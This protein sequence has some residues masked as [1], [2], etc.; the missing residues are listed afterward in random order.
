MEI[1]RDLRNRTLLDLEGYELGFDWHSSLS[2]D[3]VMVN[4]EVKSILLDVTS[5][6]Y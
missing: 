5:S 4:V 3:K 2:Y 1:V 6:Y